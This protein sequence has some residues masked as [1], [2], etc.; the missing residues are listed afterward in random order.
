M[1]LSKAIAPLVNI[2]DIFNNFVKFSTSLFLPMNRVEDL[3][4]SYEVLIEF[5]SSVHTI[6]A[7]IIDPLAFLKI[8]NSYKK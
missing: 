2:D 5:L 3:K 1:K 7:R 8:K 6:E 4:E